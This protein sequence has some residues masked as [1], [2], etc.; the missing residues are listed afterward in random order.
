MRMPFTSLTFKLFFVCLIFVFSVVLV[1]FQMSSSVLKQEVRSGNDLFIQ[2]MLSKVDQYI[3]LSFSSLETV[4]YAV[5][6]SYSDSK[7]LSEDIQPILRK[8]YSMNAGS[9]AEVYLISGNSS[10]IGGSP[11][12]ILFNEPDQERQRLFEMVM[13]NKNS[14]YFSPPYYSRQHGWTVTMAKYIAGS[15]PPLAAALD[16]DLTEIEKSLLLSTPT[17]RCSSP[18]WIPPGSWW[19]GI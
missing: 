9:V 7:S 3:S 5:E 8:L 13:D 1:L 14:I 10:M 11:R 15:S 2:Q 18:S 17:I 12:S 19:P 4:L 6:A 16:I